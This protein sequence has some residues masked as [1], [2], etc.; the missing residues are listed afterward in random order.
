[1]VSQ[2]DDHTDHQFAVEWVA[3]IARD[4]ADDQMRPEVRGLGR[5]I[6]RWRDVILAW[7]PTGRAGGGG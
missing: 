3:E 1:V 6:G 7:Q 4:F 2:I 5:T